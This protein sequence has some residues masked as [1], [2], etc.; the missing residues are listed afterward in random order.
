MENFEILDK[1][2]GRLET[3]SLGIDGRIY[4]ASKVY[5]LGVNVKF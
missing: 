2:T 5:T 1:I 3:L 4:P